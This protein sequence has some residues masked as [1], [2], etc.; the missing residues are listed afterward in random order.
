MHVQDVQAQYR[1]LF[2]N[3]G[4][5][6]HDAQESA[7]NAIY[8]KLQAAHITPDVTA[9]LQDL[10]DVVDLGVSLEAPHST[11]SKEYELSKIDFN[12]LRA[13]FESTKHK[14]IIAM[15]IM[16]K[17]EERLKKMVAQNPTRV[18]LYERYQ[19]IMQDYNKDKDAA[20]IQRVMDDLFATFDNL[21][22]EARRFQ[23]EGLDNE[24]QL[25]VFDLLQKESLKPKQRDA[26]KQVAIELLAKLETNNLLIGHW[27]DM[28]ATQAKLRLEI[29]NH[30]WA[31]DLS[32]MGYS[33]ADIANK[34]Q[35]V[36]THL[37]AATSAEGQRVLH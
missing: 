36:F 32:D 4:L 9:L 25:A 1:G 24:Q 35:A 34:V 30:L 10:Y 11:L 19:E 16:E 7:I 31:N 15:N 23:R 37:F 21:D 8:N 17:I 28:A 18:E 12:R 27:R 6:D 26:I 20:E 3:P 14:N 2:P 33:E 22:E 13:E 29:E 5:Y